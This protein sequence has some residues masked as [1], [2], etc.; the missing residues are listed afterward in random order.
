MACA[1]NWNTELVKKLIVRFFFAAQAE[2]V[3]RS[4]NF[5]PISVARTKRKKMELS[6][7]LTPTRILIYSI[8]SFWNMQCLS[9]SPHIFLAW[10]ILWLVPGSRQ[11]LED[12]N[13]ECTK[14]GKLVSRPT[15]SLPWTRKTS[16]EFK[17]NMWHG[18]MV[19][20]N[21]FAT[22]YCNRLGK[23]L[24]QTTFG[25][26]TLEFNWS[27]QHVWHIFFHAKTCKIETCIFNVISFDTVSSLGIFPEK[28]G[29]LSAQQLHFVDPCVN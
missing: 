12:T 14:L 8:A 5:G 29:K 3:G 27:K 17:L 25:W 2:R 15:N 1:H 16:L 24:N 4:T 23:C 22:L 7:L 19:Q 10:H 20:S 21:V 26:T 9:N 11:I 13:R 18:M 28:P 6:G